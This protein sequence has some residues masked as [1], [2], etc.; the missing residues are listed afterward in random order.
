MVIKVAPIWLDF[1]LRPNRCE[2]CPD[3]MQRREVWVGNCSKKAPWGQL[4]WHTSCEQ[5]THHFVS[6]EGTKLLALGKG[7]NLFRQFVLV[8]TF[9]LVKS[10]NLKTKKINRLELLG[11]AKYGRPW[12]YLYHLMWKGK[13]WCV[14][15]LYGVVFVKL[16][17][18]VGLIWY[19][20]RHFSSILP[21]QY[22]Y[23]SGLSSPIGKWLEHHNRAPLFQKGDL[24]Y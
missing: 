7:Y 15:I 17:V 18:S 4:Y 16:Y 12:L 8:N 6:F 22:Q 14:G 24:D 20:K 5:Q 19:L 2:K 23:I 10:C 13:L 9:S 21:P 1:N 11:E 3:T